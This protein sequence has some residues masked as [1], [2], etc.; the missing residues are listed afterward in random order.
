MFYATLKYST[1]MRVKRGI[2]SMMINEPVM[3]VTSNK[4]VALLTILILAFVLRLGV[5]VYWQARVGE[6]FVFGDSLSY[7]SLAESISQG[8][9]YVYGS[10]DAKIFRTPGYPLMLAPLFLIWSG[11]PPIMAAR[12]LGVFWGTLGVWGVW[13]LARELFGDR[14]GIIAAALAAVYPGAVAMS[15]LVL[16]E[17]A[18]CPLVICHLAFWVAA[19]REERRSRATI[20]AVWAGVVSGAATLVRPEWLLFTPFAMTV[21]LLLCRDRSRQLGLGAV[22][23]LAIVVVMTPWWI[24]NAAVSGRF[25]PTTLQVGVSLYDGQSPVANGAS[26]MDFVEPFVEELRREKPVFSDDLFEYRLDRMAK[27]RA[28]NWSTDNP[29]QVLHLT[30]VKFFRMWNV[31]PNEPSL[32]AWPIRLGIAIVYLPVVLL[33]IWGGVK[34]FGRGWPYVL[35]WI[36]AVYLTLL[37]VIFVSS[38]R[39]RQPAMFGFIVLSSG[40]LAIWGGWDVAQNRVGKLVEKR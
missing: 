1:I 23:M 28:L 40:L 31:W 20:L 18:F 19:W 25:V 22:T 34:T 2:L 39:Y 36:P 35:C 14:A 21:G 12:V 38:I 32:S 24:R 11:E 4:R 8:E 26:N 17:S 9:P 33:G 15:V 3:K 16:S 5:A 13:W 29:A 27:S 6:R 37:H 30:V 7:W 10:Y